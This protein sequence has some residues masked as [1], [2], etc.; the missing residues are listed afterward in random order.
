[1]ERLRKL[2]AR[3]E[4]K[5]RQSFSW[6]LTLRD[7]S[8]AFP[9][10]SHEGLDATIRSRCDDTTLN[11]ISM[12]YR[13][14]TVHIADGEDRVLGI[15]PGCGGLQGDGKMPQ[16]FRM[17][18]SE[19]VHDYVDAKG[20][21]NI[22]GEDPLTGERVDAGT[23]VFADDLAELHTV[24]GADDAVG[25][26]K[27]HTDLMTTKLAELDMAQN[28]DKAEHIVH[29][30]GSGASDATK[31]CARMLSDKGL[32]KAADQARYLGNYP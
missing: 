28:I 16:H 11:L 32:G 29:M 21:R 6:V 19:G 1:M 30:C 23:T 15:R 17:A 27:H 10:I 2:A 14:A 8:N 3:T 9:S 24:S 26:I 20:W 5:W 7:V 12:R 22:L 25:M 4:A 31:R 18:Y 13:E